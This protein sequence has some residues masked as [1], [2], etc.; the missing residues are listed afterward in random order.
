MPAAQSSLAS[1]CNRVCVMHLARQLCV[2]CGRTLDEIARWLDL[3]DAERAQIMVQLPSRLAAAS[4][5]NTAPA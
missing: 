3:G 1:P 2:G 4:N 5:P